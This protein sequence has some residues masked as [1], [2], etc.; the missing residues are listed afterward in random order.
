MALLG[1]LLTVLTSLMAMTYGVDI[2]DGIDMY[3]TRTVLYSRYMGSMT[4]CQKLCT[5]SLSWQGA[6]YRGPKNA[7]H[8]LSVISLENSLKIRM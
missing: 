7:N 6:P 1:S 2:G 8:M 3:R 5:K 4:L